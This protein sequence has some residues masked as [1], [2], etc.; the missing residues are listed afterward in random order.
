MSH[1]KQNPNYKNF[2]HFAW[3]TSPSKGNKNIYLTK[4]INKTENELYSFEVLS[5]MGHLEHIFS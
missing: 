1:M 5:R 3:I 4:Q 2:L